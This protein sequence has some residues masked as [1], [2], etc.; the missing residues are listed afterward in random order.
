M[1][2][3]TTE[4]NLK[5]LHVSDNGLPDWRIEKAA[6]SAKKRGDDVYFAGG[7]SLNLNTF[8][9]TTFDRN[10]VF[11]LNWDYKARYYYPQEWKDLKGQLFGIIRDCKPDI[12]HTHDIFAAQL[13]R[14]LN[15]LTGTPWIYDNHE[16]WSRSIIY[17]Y[18]QNDYFKQRDPTHAHIPNLWRK[19]EIDIIN[20]DDIP[21]IVPSQRIAEEINYFNCNPHVFVVPNYPSYE[22]IKDIPEPQLHKEIQSVFTSNG[23]PNLGKVTPIKN[24][25]GFF[26]L[27]DTGNLGQLNTIG[28]NDTSGNFIH[29]HGPIPHN[30]MYS[31]LTQFDLGIIP[32]KHHPFHPY[33]SPNRAYEYAHAGLLVFVPESLETVIN[34]LD[35]MVVPIKN[36]D[37]IALT[38]EL[39]ESNPSLLFEYRLKTYRHAREHLLWENYEGN[40][41]DAYNKAL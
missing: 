16:Y 19:W 11:T 14:E 41:F 24:L 38:I 39:Y 9:I 40:I 8:N 10:K 30:K 36:Y 12:I 25:D 23:K 5:I 20:N 32:W 28:W 21:V 33:C 3:T 27:F 1:T 26:D 2:I 34:D 29:H 17:Q 15:R 13:V 37:D 31:L 4:S 7:T 22:E 6:L 35:G 18:L